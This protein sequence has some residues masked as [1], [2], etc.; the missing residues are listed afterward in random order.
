MWLKSHKWVNNPH[1]VTE[2]RR[3]MNVRESTHTAMVFDRKYLN[4]ETGK[5]DTDKL[6]T[7][8]SMSL[9]DLMDEGDSSNWINTYVRQARRDREQPSAN[10]YNFPKHVPKDN[11]FDAEIRREKELKAQ[12]DKE[13]AEKRLAEHNKIE[14]IEREKRR[15]AYEEFKKKRI[16]EERKSEEEYAKQLAETE[17]RLMKERNERFERMQQANQLRHSGNVRPNVWKPK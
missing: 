5:F 8:N 12:Q 2:R 9:L 15:L 16:N 6:C 11:D 10:T 4:I 7:L 17:E 1:T 13:Y 3:E 14:A